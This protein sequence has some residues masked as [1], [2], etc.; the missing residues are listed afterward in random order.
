MAVWIYGGGF[1]FG[2]TQNNDAS[3]LIKKSVSLGK[4]IVYVQMNYRLSGFGFMPGKEIL[5]SGN[6][7]IGL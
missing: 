4:D 6:G 7:N 3:K 1:E 2:S 5:Q